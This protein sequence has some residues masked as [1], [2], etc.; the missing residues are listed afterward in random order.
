MAPNVDSYLATARALGFVM[1]SVG[2]IVGAVA[3]SIVGYIVYRLGRR[4]KNTYLAI[5]GGVLMLFTYVVTDT[6][7]VYSIGA[8][9]CVAAW[10]AYASHEDD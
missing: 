8:G 5:L 1:P 2:Y 9:L 4:T 7:L 3:F 6:F 10:A